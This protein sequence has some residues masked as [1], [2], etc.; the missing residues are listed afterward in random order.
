MKIVKT[1]ILINKPN[2]IFSNGCFQQALFL[3]KTLN[4]IE[5]IQCDLI[6]FDPE[7]NVF[8]QLLPIKIILLDEKTV[9]DYDI[10]FTLS[11]TFQKSS[12]IFNLIRSNNVKVIDVLCG[13][14]F[15]LLQEEFVFDC[16]KIMHNYQNEIIDEVWVLEMYAYSIEYLEL[17]FNKPVK[18]L[19]YM[20]DSDIIKQYL[21]TNNIKI[22]RNKNDVVN[23]I[24]TNDVNMDTNEINNEKINICIYEPNLSLHKNSFIPLL[25]AERYFKN[26]PTRLHKVYIFCKEKL[27]NN[28]FINSLSLVKE[29]KVE[30]FGRYVFPTTISM[31]QQNNNFKNVV[32][33]YTFLNNL[34]FLHLESM[35]MRI[36]IV[37]NCEPFQNGLYYHDYNFKFAC[38]L[39]ETARNTEDTLTKSIDILCKYNTRNTSIQNTWKTEIFNLMKEKM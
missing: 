34:N 27:P 4:L 37:H 13:N 9:V 15:I 18:V 36:P 1:G 2:H 38:E 16:H 11:S 29:N 5:G 25:I 19:P 32:L 24:K 22:N 8:D 12:E 31:I 7:Y 28:S 26:N 10:I 20:W 21:H 39:L 33:S 23:K 3:Y 14:L 17:F 6:S 30:T 35:Y